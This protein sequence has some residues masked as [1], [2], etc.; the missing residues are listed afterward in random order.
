MIDKTEKR[1][2]E[3]GEFVRGFVIDLNHLAEDGWSVL[4]EGKRDA[5]ALRKLGFVGNLVTIYLLTK[6]GNSALE[7]TRKVMI[8]TDCI[9]IDVAHRE[10]SPAH[11]HDYHFGG[12]LCDGL[13][14]GDNQQQ[15]I[16]SHYS[17]HCA[18]ESPF[19]ES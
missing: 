11:L 9:E 18:A 17:Q 2:Q 15:N 7:G 3:F 8:L 4:V 13:C 16:C 1:Y 5:A 6:Y 14:T 19:T 10:V 12:R